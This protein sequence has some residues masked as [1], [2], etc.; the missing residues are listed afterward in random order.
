MAVSYLSGGGLIALNEHQWNTGVV[1]AG[2]LPDRKI[3]SESTWRGVVEQVTGM[4]DNIRVHTFDNTVYSSLKPTHDLSLHPGQDWAG[5]AWETDRGLLSQ[6]S[7]TQMR[8]GQ[9]NY[10]QGTSDPFVSNMPNRIKVST[11]LDMASF[12]TQYRSARNEIAGPKRPISAQSCSAGTRKAA[13]NAFASASS[14]Q[15]GRAAGRVSLSSKS[16]SAGAS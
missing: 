10:L 15:F 11:R 7:K 1:Q 3:E 6:A 14:C 9:M 8:I 12:E 16:M 4:Y 5:R 13:A 2:H